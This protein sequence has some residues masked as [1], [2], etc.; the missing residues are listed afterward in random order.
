MV[1]TTTVTGHQDHLIDVMPPPEADAG[2]WLAK[3]APYQF[4]NNSFTG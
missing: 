4:S 3:E 1:G 2:S